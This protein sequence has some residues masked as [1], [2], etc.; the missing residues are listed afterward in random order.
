MGKFRVEIKAEAEKQIAQHYKSGDRGSIKKIQK[1]LEDLIEHP[2]LGEGNPEPLKYE[3][4]G[5]W[6]RRINQKNRLVY[7]V[8]EDIVTVF[9][10]SAMGHYSDK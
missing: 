2:F 3:L 8:D 9:V 5:F 6:S 1:I 7:F 4:G 10:I